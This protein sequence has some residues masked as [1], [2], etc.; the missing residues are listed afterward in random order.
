M[1]QKMIGTSELMSSTQIFS[2][3]EIDG[4]LE[5]GKQD[6]GAE[7]NVMPLNIYDQLNLKLQGK[8]H[9]RPCNDVKIIGYSKQSVQIVG[10]VS[11]TCTHAHVIKR[12]IFY[13]TNMNDTKILLGLNFCRAFNL[14]TIHCN[15]QCV[16]KKLAINIIKIFPKGFDVPNQTT[17][18]FLPPPVDIEADIEAETRL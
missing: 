10:K 5:R 8:L 7:V 11:V 18:Q 17:R 6:T 1:L 9:L 13:V 16:C 4:I 3:I 2:N 15:D 12:Y 14:V